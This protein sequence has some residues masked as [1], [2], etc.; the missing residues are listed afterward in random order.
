MG[1]VGPE[2]ID[3]WPTTT[4]PG[5]WRPREALAAMVANVDDL[6]REPHEGGSA[7]G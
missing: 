4:N 2:Q 5:D 6:L 1:A 7:G 3:S